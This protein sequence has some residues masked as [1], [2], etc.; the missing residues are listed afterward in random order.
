[1]SSAPQREDDV[2]FAPRYDARGL[3][4]AIVQD[5]DT[6]Q[7]LMVAHMN[8]EAVDRTLAT[9]EAHFWSRSRGRLWR[10]GETS[11]EVQ[12]IV[13]ILVDCDQDAILLRVK[14]RGKGVAC[15]TGRRSCFYRRLVSASRR[16]EDVDGVAAHAI[17]PSRPD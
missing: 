12:G 3:V 4:T 10:K 8:A 2:V 9:G 13:E 5:A 16:L 11:G 1:M 15:H 7:V 14:P 17:A 6:K